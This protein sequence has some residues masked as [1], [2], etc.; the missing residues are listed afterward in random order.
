MNFIL[1]LFSDWE[2]DFQQQVPWNNIFVHLIPY[3]KCQTV[4]ILIWGKCIHA[5]KRWR[6]CKQF[7][8]CR[9]CI[10]FQSYILSKIMYPLTTTETYGS[11]LLLSSASN[12]LDTCMTL[13]TVALV[14]IQVG[15]MWLEMCITS[16][17]GGYFLCSPVFNPF[18]KYKFLISSCNQGSMRLAKKKLL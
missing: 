10:L 5:N 4:S 7:L 18:E 11:L 1:S 3:L 15:D 17:P 2:W 16:L 12:E 6:Y 8:Q 9:I 14:R 13:T